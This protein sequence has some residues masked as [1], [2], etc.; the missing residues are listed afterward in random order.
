[1]EVLAPQLPFPQTHYPLG[2]PIDPEA[3]PEGKKYSAEQA[4]LL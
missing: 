4:L 1:L 3:V 2:R